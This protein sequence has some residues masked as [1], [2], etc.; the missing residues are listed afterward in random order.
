MQ[1][2]SV[3]NATKAVGTFIWKACGFIF[4]QLIFLPSFTCLVQLGKRSKQQSVIICTLC[5]LRSESLLSVHL[6]NRV[7]ATK[8]ISRITSRND[9]RSWKFKWQPP[10]QPY[11]QSSRVY[12]SAEATSYSDT[13]IL[14]VL[15]LCK[16]TV[17]VASWSKKGKKKGEKK[18]L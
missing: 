15:W 13:E 18:E 14:S 9:E 16:F 4:F 17:V 5:D 3:S 1:I 8:K 6:F 2:G 10:Q 11:S 7:S 12:S